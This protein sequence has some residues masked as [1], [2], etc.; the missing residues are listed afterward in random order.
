MTVRAVRKIS[1]QSMV[2]AGLAR[3]TISQFMARK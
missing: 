1:R 2:E 3:G